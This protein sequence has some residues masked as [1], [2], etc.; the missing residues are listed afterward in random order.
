MEEYKAIQIPSRGIGVGNKDAKTA[1][2]MGT[3]GMFCALG[4][5]NLYL[6]KEGDNLQG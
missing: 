4:K 3:H 1:G 5:P 2:T 6:R